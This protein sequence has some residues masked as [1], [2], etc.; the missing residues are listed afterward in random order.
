MAVLNTGDLTLLDFAK[1]L[2]PNG[3]IANVA[4]LLSQANEWMEDAVYIEANNTTSHRSV[5]RTG[6]PEVY[7]R[8]I[9][10]GVPSSKSTTVQVDEAMSML[11]AFPCVDTALA[12]LNANK[13]KFLLSE[14]RPFIES[15]GQRMSRAIFYGNPTGSPMEFQGL[16][17]RYSDSTAGNGQNILT[18]SAAPATGCTSMWLVGWGED[19]VCCAFPKGSKAGLQYRD[20]G[21][22]TVQDINGNDYRAYRTH[23]KWDNGLVVRDWRYAVRIANLRKQNL[24]AVGASGDTMPIV[25]Y[26]SRALDRIPSLST[27]RPAFYANRTVVSALRIQALNKSA[28][29][30][31]IQ[32]AITQFG[33]TI[34]Q[35][36]F[37]GVPV[38]IV[39]QLLNT[40]EA[41]A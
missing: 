30:L 34:Q 1:R 20:L 19:S 18:A 5:I 13:A 3:N 15:M 35:L 21:E 24:D 9:N 40:E 36:T 26:M 7:F 2:D 28:N 41:V 14:N 8:A 32:P 12:N 4:E 39:D 29:A 11:E 33:N 23:Y 38:R 22:E 10:K 6:L 16:A 31:A 27:C 37:L 25:E 17:P